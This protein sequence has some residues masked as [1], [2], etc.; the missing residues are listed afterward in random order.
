M[1]GINDVVEELGDDVFIRQSKSMDNNELSIEQLHAIN[2]GVTSGGNGVLC[3]T[4]TEEID[5][6]T[7][8]GKKADFM[9]AK[10]ISLTDGSFYYWR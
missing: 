2:G 1:I 6:I 5:A 7:D 3:F 9:K 10:R 4:G 8:G